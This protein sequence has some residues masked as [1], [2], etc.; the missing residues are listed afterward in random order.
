MWDRDAVVLP[1]A[2]PADPVAVSRW[3]PSAGL[4]IRVDGAVRPGLAHE[5]RDFADG[6]TAFRITL[7]GPDHIGTG[8]RDMWVWAVP[9]AMELHPL[10]LS[11]I[12]DDPQPGDAVRIPRGA[13]LPPTLGDGTTSAPSSTGPTAPHSRYR[14]GSAAAGTRATPST[15]T[16]TPT[17]SARCA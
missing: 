4:G 15:C 9:A 5:R 8:R 10:G 7:G 12:E 6:R 11:F 14:S 3:E 17:A 1:A 16:G 13:Q 2:L